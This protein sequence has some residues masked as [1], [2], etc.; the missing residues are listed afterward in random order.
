M[1][2][3][4]VT[5]QSVILARTCGSNTPEGGGHSS[6]LLSLLIAASLP[7]SGDLS[8][9]VYQNAQ[10]PTEPFRVDMKHHFHHFIR[11]SDSIRE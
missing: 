7:S 3:S 1:Q 8:N 4:S 6:Q 10:V 2:L 5:M 11:R 9:D